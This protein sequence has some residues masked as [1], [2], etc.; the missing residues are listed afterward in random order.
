MKKRIILITIVLALL[1]GIAVLVFRNAPSDASSD[2]PAA[3]TV[4][5]DGSVPV[6]ISGEGED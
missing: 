3:S 6:G 5:P 4:E 1:L 2:N